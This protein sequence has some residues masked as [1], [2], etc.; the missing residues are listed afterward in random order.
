M[1]L[2]P[3]ILAIALFSHV[4]HAQRLIYRGHERLP[5]DEAPGLSGITYAGDGTYWGV[6]EWEAK[7]IRLRIPTRDDASIE[8][9]TIDRTVQMRRGTDF[10]GIAFTSARPDAVMVS[11]ESPGVVEVSLKDG[12]AK[13]SLELPRLFQQIV[14]NQGLE[15][16]T[17]SHDGQ[18]LWTANERA[19]KTDGNPQQPIT[20]FLAATRVRLLRYDRAGDTFEPAAQFEYE[21]GGVHGAAGQ[22]GLCDLAALP[23]GRLLSLERSAAQGLSGKKSIRSRIY[24]VDPADATDISRQPFNAGLVGESPIKVSKTLLFDGFVCDDNGENLEGLCIGPP[25]ARGRFAILAVVDNT[26][27]GVGVSAPA[28][29]AFELDLTAPPTTQPAGAANE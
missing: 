12:R 22:I 11:T 24:L 17:Y 28:V 13:H 18:T 27:G 9:V 7:L 26:D 10:E 6:L 2:I 23:D 16:L 8:S 21:S 19:L 14:R 29:V 15:S 20:P 4:V 1:R 3:F 25:L 5:E